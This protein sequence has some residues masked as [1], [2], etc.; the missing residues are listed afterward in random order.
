MEVLE[1]I[2]LLSKN[3]GC[4]D[5]MKLLLKNIHHLEMKLL[6]IKQDRSDLDILNK[7]ILNQIITLEILAITVI[8]MVIMDI[9]VDID[10]FMGKIINY[11]LCNI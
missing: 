7:Y 8:T 9:M 4:L 3:K 6:S 5:N 1:A 2:K 10:R 11:E